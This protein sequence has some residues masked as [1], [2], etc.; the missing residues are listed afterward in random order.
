MQ[1]HGKRWTLQTTITDPIREDA[2]AA[3]A[4]EFA[5]IEQ[6]ESA[7]LR[8]AFVEYLDKRRVAIDEGKAKKRKG[9]R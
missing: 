6:W 5:Q 4:L 2:L 8:T 9:P 3:K 1:K 7:M